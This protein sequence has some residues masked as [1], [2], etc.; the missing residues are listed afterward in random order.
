MDKDTIEDLIRLV[1]WK[2]STIPKGHGGKYKAKYDK[3]TKILKD[4]EGELNAN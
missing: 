3:W 1:E 2:I 4:L